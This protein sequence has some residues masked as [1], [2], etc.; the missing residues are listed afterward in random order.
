VG[1]GDFAGALD[2]FRAA[3]RR[4][5]SRVLA[6]PVQHVEFACVR[7]RAMARRSAATANT[8]RD[9]DPFEHD[10]AKRVAQAHGRPLR[11]GFVSGDLRQH[12]VSVF[13]ESVLGGSTGRASSR[14]PM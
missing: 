1:E 6:D 2:A 5:A 10:R 8:S 12:P 11:V 9:A 3:I 14:M 7:A 13:L 4:P